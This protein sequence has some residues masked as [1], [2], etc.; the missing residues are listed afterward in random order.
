MN[1]E[2][3]ILHRLNDFQPVLPVYHKRSFMRQGGLMDF[4]QIEELLK[5]IAERLGKLFEK[6]N[7]RAL[8]FCR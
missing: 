7:D 5:D 6:I 3:D 8:Y 2:R 1:I 4:A